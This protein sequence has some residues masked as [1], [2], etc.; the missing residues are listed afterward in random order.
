MIW[1]QVAPPVLPVWA[2][3]LIGIVGVA[4]GLS[5]L[6]RLFRGMAQVVEIVPIIRLIAREFDIMEDPDDKTAKKRDPRHVFPTLIQ[7]ADEFRPNHG[8]SLKDVVT[9]IDHT[10]QEMIKE[11][12]DLKARS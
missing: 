9:R 2:Q 4:G 10:Q 6:W 7:I 11:I 8:T 1:A 3:W 12:Q 5:V